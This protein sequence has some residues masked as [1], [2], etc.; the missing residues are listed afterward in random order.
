MTAIPANT[1]FLLNLNNDLV[2]QMGVL[3][4]VYS[5][6]SVDV[7][8]QYGRARETTSGGFRY[9][10]PSGFAL[11]QIFSFEFWL[12]INPSTMEGYV[13]RSG[14]FAI[15]TDGSN[16]L[17]ILFNGSVAPY[18]F[19]SNSNCYIANNTWNHYA[20]SRDADNMIRVFRNGILFQTPTELSLAFAS[21]GTHIAFGCADTNPL[22][23]LFKGAI[24]DFIWVDSAYRT[25]PLDTPVGTHV[26]AVPTE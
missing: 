24:D 14:N 22:S 23:N 21:M 8:G 19:V 6:N 3:A 5:D 15:D 1:K 16:K 9:T 11:G 26:F 18:V 12:K 13:M 7:A 20:V 4:T 2:D 17:R 25:C 10:K